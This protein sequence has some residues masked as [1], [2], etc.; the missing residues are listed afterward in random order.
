MGH[1]SDNLIPS[2]ARI[3]VIQGIFLFIS[4]CVSYGSQFHYPRNT[5]ICILRADINMIMQTW[6]NSS[7]YTPNIKVTVDCYIP[8]HRHPLTTIWYW[9]L[10]IDTWFA[11]VNNTMAIDQ[12]STWPLNER[13]STSIAEIF[14]ILLKAEKKWKNRV[15]EKYKNAHENTSTLSTQNKTYCISSHPF[16]NTCT[17]MHMCKLRS[18]YNSQ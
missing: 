14:A 12:I 17:R 8:W 6:S 13:R 10:S 7:I 18:I 1:K 9:T 5:H 15:L 4:P 2:G 11:K 3:I 16:A